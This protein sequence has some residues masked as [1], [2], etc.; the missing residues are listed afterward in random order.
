MLC[1]RLETA[2]GIRAAV[3]PGG[4]AMQLGDV[5]RQPRPGWT[6]EDLWVPGQG[7]TRPRVLGAGMEDPERH[8]VR[9]PRV[10]PKT[11]RN[12]IQRNGRRSHFQPWA[13]SRV[14]EEI[15]SLREA[16]P[17]VFMHGERSRDPCSRIRAL[18]RR[19]F[20]PEARDVTSS[21]KSS[22]D[23]APGPHHPGLRADI[24]QA[25]LTLP[26]LSGTEAVLQSSDEPK[27]RHAPENR[28]KNS[29]LP[30]PMNLEPRCRFAIL[31]ENGNRRHPGHRV[32][33]EE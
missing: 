7:S 9:R 6:A 22:H 29:H 32:V 3:Q 26:A 11:L 30:L 4:A 25:L 8:C 14:A 5:H 12:G 23:G 28:A 31:L 33:A 13:L 16:A 1:R 2:V 15:P 27:P 21:T 17:C 10:H 19:R 24:G 20:F 18:T